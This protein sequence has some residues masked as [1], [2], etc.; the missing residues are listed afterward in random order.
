VKDRLQTKRI[1]SKEFIE[2]KVGRTSIQNAARQQAQLSYL[3]NSEI[4]PIQQDLNY[5]T[6]WVGNKFKTSDSFLTWVQ[7]IFKTDNF[8]Q[9]YSY[10][11]YPLPSAKLVKNR[12]KIDLERMFFAEDSYFKYTQGG[13][14]VETPEELQTKKFEK[15]IFNALLFRF[16]DI[17][18]TDLKEAN[19]PF[20]FI[21]PISDVVALRSRDGVISEIAYTATIADENG[22]AMEGFIYINDR[23]YIFYDKELKQ[24]PI[25]FPHDIGECPADYI[26]ANA[27][28]SDDIIREGW[29]SFQREEFEEYVFL[30]TIQK[31]T[32]PNGAVPVVTTLK[33]AP[34]QGQDNKFKGGTGADASMSPSI[35]YP[36]MKW[37]EK[38]V[39]KPITQ[40]GTVLKIGINK[41]Q[42]GSVDMG[43]V[44]D[45]INFHYIPTESLE[46][47]ESRIRSIEA[48]L[49][50]GSTG[51][52]LEQGEN[53]KN[54]L[55]IE[56][57]Y[58]GKQ[59]KL[60]SFAFEMT[61]ARDNS[62]RK[63][64]ALAHGR[65]SY[66]VEIFYGS[67]FFIETQ[68]Q[69]FKL[70]KDAPNPIERKTILTRLA[71]SRSKF[72][73]ERG[74]RDMILYKLMPYS[75]DSEFAVAVSNN[76]VGEFTFQFQIQFNYWISL[77]ESQYGDILQF[78][79][80]FDI[81]ESQKIILIHKL[82][83]TLIKENHEQ[84][85]EVEESTADNSSS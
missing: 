48:S 71:K 41:K 21:L 82:I 32:E 54:E 79:N 83:L 43:L 39:E 15:Q 64:L 40:G 36:D 24:T 16:N 49:L 77:F 75:S 18:I 80:L 2:R 51:D 65:D 67:D 33:T 45:F 10:L 50:A 30:K 59:D 4:Q 73:P 63:F 69:L 66:R 9:F 22:L 38:K 19:T 7:T 20:R 34:P 70:L 31:M 78:W 42:D 81:E 47:L 74:E 61:K 8:M 37:G 57:S 11:R 23:E 12:I 76:A 72:N 14:E 6:T 53:T 28:G 1:V 5:L 62:D 55:Q 60:R 25:V 26:A 52:F 85:K 44:K 29:F 3:T 17:I 84:P 27:F 56:R 46:F 68:A 35:L 58:M 13:T